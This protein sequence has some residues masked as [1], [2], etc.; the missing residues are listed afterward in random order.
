MEETRIDR[1]EARLDEFAEE[2]RSGF[3]AVDARLCKIEARMDQFATK[4]ELSELRSELRSE[5][6]RM[7]AELKMWMLATMVTIIGTVLATAFGLH[8]WNG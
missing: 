5:M 8:H 3:R 1:L 4:L 2:M 7:N 6:Y